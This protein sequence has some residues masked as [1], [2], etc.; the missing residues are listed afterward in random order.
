[1]AKVLLPLGPWGVFAIAAID[2]A[3]FGLPMDA[4]VA[5]YVYE[6]PSWALIFPLMAALGSALGS[7]IIYAIG[8]KGGEMALRKRISH[9]RFEKIRDRF[10]RQ[11]FFALMIPAMLP[12]PTPF[13]LFVFAAGALEMRARDFLLAIFV[14]RLVR[15]A[16]LA[17]L[18]VEFGPRI[19]EAIPA[20]FHNHPELK[21]LLTIAAVLIALLIYFLLRRPVI[22]LAEE[23]EK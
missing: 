12:P 13:K 4:I 8:R 21:I 9:A 3:A 23:M 15:F 10:E 7:L 1:M 2:A 22:E 19:V 17:G 16:I 5:G 6:R 11:E 18:V 20:L 14:G